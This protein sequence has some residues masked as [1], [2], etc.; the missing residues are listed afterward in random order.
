MTAQRA[1]ARLRLRFHGMLDSSLSRVQTARERDGPAPSAQTLRQGIVMPGGF[2]QRVIA[3]AR[4]EPAPSEEQLILG[5]LQALLNTRQ[6][7][8]KLDPNYGVPDFTALLHDFPAGARSL[9][10][11][12]K[13]AITRYE[14]R[15]TG[16]V[17]RAT[18]VS[19]NTLT[20]HMEL[21]ARLTRSPSHALKIATQVFRSGHIEFG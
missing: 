20:L 13:Q 12:V 6:G 7:S 21:Q 15:L 17:V 9:E 10:Q 3:L 19:T 2:L 4:A 5:H 14:P 8:S 16:V 18:R 1:W 11:A